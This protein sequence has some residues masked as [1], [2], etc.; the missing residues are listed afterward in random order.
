[1]A[2]RFHWTDE[3]MVHGLEGAWVNF[4]ALKESEEQNEQLR[5]QLEEAAKESVRQFELQTKANRESFKAEKQVQRMKAVVDVA[6]VCRAEMGD[7]TTLSFAA[8]TAC[9]NLEAAVDELD[10]AETDG[11]EG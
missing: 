4:F 6:V 2:G 9:E 1:M 7:I 8:L 11:G 5:A 3:G 10:K